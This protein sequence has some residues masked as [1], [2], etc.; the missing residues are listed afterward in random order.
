MSFN[1]IPLVLLIVL[2]SIS[3]GI[4]I[5]DHGNPRGPSNAWTALIALIIQGGLITWLVW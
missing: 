3:F 5:A 1:L 2:Y 4:H